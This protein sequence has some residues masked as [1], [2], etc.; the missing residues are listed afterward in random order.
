MSEYTL[1]PDAQEKIR[2]HAFEIKGVLTHP[3]EALHMG[4]GDLGA[5]VNLYSH[6]IKITLAKTDVWDARY[7]GNP[8]KW[9]LKH[10]DL[11][12]MMKEKN[13]DLLCPFPNLDGQ[14]GDDY[15]F[16]TPA[17]GFL[18][19]VC[20]PG[21][22][23]VGAIRLYHPG[24]SNTK[25]QSRLEILTGILTTTFHF[26]DSMLIV[27]T[28]LHKTENVI[29]MEVEAVG[30]APWFALIIEKEPDDTDR[31]IP[32]P[33]IT[34]EGTHIGGISQHIPAGF[35]ID[36]FR[37]DMVGMFP[38]ATSDGCVDSL[39]PETHAF[40]LRQYC[41]LKENE[42]V[43]FCVAITTTRDGEGDSFDRAV[44]MLKANIG[45]YE[46]KKR[47]HSI[48]WKRFWAVSGIE[49]DD[50]ALEATWYRNHFH[51][52][53]ALR[54]G[55][56]TLGIGGN[57][58]ITDYTPWHGD[59][60]M[61]HNFQKWYVTA[62]PTNHPEWID[63]YADFIEQKMPVF[64]YQAELIFGLEGVYCDS[65]YFPIMIKEQCN[66]NNYIGRALALTGWLGQPLWWHWEYM[67]D[68][69]WLKNR[70]YPYLKK[71]AQFYWRY[72]EKYQDESGDIYPS[73][74]I[75]EPG[76]VKGFKSNRNVI[77]DLVMFKKT[78]ER[79]IAAAEVLGLDEDWRKKWAKGITR[80]PSIE[81]G[82]DGEEAWIALDK[83]FH[84]L[85]PGERGDHTRY[86]RWGG[87]GWAIFPGEYITGYDDDELTR[88]Y[89]DV[90]ER[91][92]LLN[93]F[94]SVTNQ[95]NM[96]RGVPL[97]HP[98]SSVL[99]S[100]RLGLDA[101]FDD[102]R[103]I[104]LT[105]RMPSGQSC[106]YQMSTGKIPKEVYGYYGF[107]WYDWRSVENKYVGVIATT[108]MLLQ[109]HGEIL[110]LFPMWPKGKEAAFSKLRARGGFIVSGR[111]DRTGQ[112]TAYIE[113]V[114]D[115]TCC[116]GAPTSVSVASQGVPIAVQPGEE[117]VSF[118][119]KKGMVYEV[120]IP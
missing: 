115:G 70:A 7:D 53:C 51:Y 29:W 30:P 105:H 66:V 48:Q 57:T 74:R 117:S 50:K 92:D 80:V 59:C 116:I 42:K 22:K 72:L 25:V 111:Q 110:R 112:I 81:F 10:D 94:Y 21:P 99:P 82:W 58:V 63:I 67:R 83:F 106:S 97:V 23:R 61:N 41:S 34:R 76:W 64:E 17:Y 38:E 44:D 120:V 18:P 73:I 60:H 36:D 71:A 113:S 27:R 108:E 102:I 90:L 85:E 103:E 9:T 79:A 88:A 31:T 68:K 2:Q 86:D 24:L 95:K 11:I 19:Y 33:D 40:K 56:T 78:F 13:R 62:F 32:L 20:G 1:T 100:I 15:H 28:F 52:E 89:K 65:I 3:F 16:E 35:G 87:G 109:S 47:S 96:Y 107:L 101:K 8:E 104:I 69:E 37:W 49:L 118:Y 6:E 119:A 91:T 93:P 45:R 98:I 75:E 12:A 4:N 114:A 14:R 55:A 77:S 26:S 5:S 43:Q 39:A 54:R 84:E 46:E